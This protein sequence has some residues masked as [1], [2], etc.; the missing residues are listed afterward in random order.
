MNGEQGAK[1]KINPDKNISCAREGAERGK[2]LVSAPFEV[3]TIPNLPNI[4]TNTSSISSLRFL[5]TGRITATFHLPC[6]SSNISVF[7]FTHSK[8]ISDYSIRSSNRR[9]RKR[10]FLTFRTHE[11]SAP[12]PQ[13]DHC[14]NEHAKSEKNQIPHP[15][16]DDRTRQ[17]HRT[18]VP[19][20]KKRTGCLLETFSTVSRRQPAHLEQVRFEN[21]DPFSV[22]PARK[23]SSAIAIS[24]ADPVST[25]SGKR[26]RI[27][28]GTSM[29]RM[30][31]APAGGRNMPVTA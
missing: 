11:I 29:G 23:N 21:Q 14:E 22:F 16:Q 26:N 20:I 25:C 31:M 2:R 1:T 12:A 5:Q 7:L 18:H 28:S 30:P 9:V 4:Y 19:W 3:E 24:T 10:A 27:F 13:T 17:D 15:P 6:I 8:T